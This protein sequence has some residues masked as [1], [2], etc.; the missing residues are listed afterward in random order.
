METKED[1]IK[2]AIRRL[3]KISQLHARIEQ[4]PIKVEEGLVLTT[5]EVHTLVA[6]AEQESISITQLA[7]RFGVSKSASS[8]MVN[9]LEKRDLLLK[10]QAAHSNKEY[11]LSL[12]EQGWKAFRAHEQYRGRSRDQL[13]SKLSG[14]SIAQI[15][16]LSVLLEEMENT[17]N[18]HL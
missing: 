11:E 17:M 13:I 18:K 12:T 2:L 14:F 6:I 1:L 5:R 3:L 8:Q 7:A 9:K 16:T 4:T 15:A 10:R